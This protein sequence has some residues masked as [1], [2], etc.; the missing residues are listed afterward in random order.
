MLRLR[1]GIAA[2]RLR[3]GWRLTWAYLKAYADLSS[4]LV[5]RGS[6]FQA[7]ERRGGKTTDADYMRRA[8]A[9]F[10]LMVLEQILHLDAGNFRS[11]QLKGDPR[12]CR[13]LLGKDFTHVL[14]LRLLSQVELNALRGK[15]HD[16]IA[17]AEHCD[18]EEV[19]DLLNDVQI[20]IDVWYNDWK[21]IVQTTGTAETP[22]LLLNLTVQKYWSQAV[23]AC[24]ALRA[25]G[26]DNIA[27][28]SP[29]QV[30]HPPYG[31]DRVE[32][33]SPSDP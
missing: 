9:W 25:L 28:M 18:E 31:K 21:G 1:A 3:P 26:N 22:V 10:Q 30:G 29:T 6:S 14:D 20:D 24:R 7:E 33:A 17:S 11:F 13:V 23:A 27:A 16:S 19:M 8:R 5:A 2:L 12:R 4:R 15:V 32:R